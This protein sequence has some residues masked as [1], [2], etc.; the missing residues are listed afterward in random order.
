MLRLFM[1]ESAPYLF[2]GL[3]RRTPEDTL[4]AAFR[5]RHNR[6]S[7]QWAAI[8]EADGEVAGVLNAF[9]WSR[10]T[11]LNIGLGMVVLGVHGPLGLL[12]MLGRLT[13]KVGMRAVA[14]GEYFI[15]QLAVLPEF[16][17]R[18]VGTRLL[19]HA[20]QHARTHGLIKCSLLVDAHNEG[21]RR[22]YERTGYRVVYSGTIRYRVPAVRESAYHRMVKELSHEPA[23]G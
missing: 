17:R 8:C 10:A 3:S 18:G 13:P 7:W 11:A 6:L 23:S 4:V 5:T 12:R 16:Q 21:A 1:A 15:S 14:R 20:E 22:L 2:A 9:P 19:A